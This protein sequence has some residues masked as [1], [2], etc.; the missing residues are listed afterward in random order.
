MVVEG[1]MGYMEIKFIPIFKLSAEDKQVYFHI[2]NKKLIIIIKCNDSH[3]FSLFF[4]LHKHILLL[5]F[6]PC[7]IYTLIHK[8]ASLC[9]FIPCLCSLSLWI[10]LLEDFCLL[11][12]LFC[13]LLTQTLSPCGWLTVSRFLY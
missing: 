10:I 2:N 1:P 3:S 4:I 9:L 6:I 11:A 8:H 13:L 12:G 7:R 5:L